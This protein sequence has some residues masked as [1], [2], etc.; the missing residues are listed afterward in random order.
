M[1]G[2]DGAWKPWISDAYE[3]RASRGLTCH[4][5]GPNSKSQ[6]CL[7]M[8][9]NV[10]EREARHLTVSW[11]LQPLKLDAVVCPAP[12]LY[13]AQVPKHQWRLALHQMRIEIRKHERRCDKTLS[14]TGGAW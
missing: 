4:D 13:P 1:L 12:C 14:E 8:C 7:H 11:A 10:E 3:M 5:S 9:E 6:I 2:L